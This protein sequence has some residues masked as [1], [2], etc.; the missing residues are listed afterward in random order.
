MFGEREPVQFTG[1]FRVIRPGL[2]EFQ[3]QEV[4]V[5]DLTVPGALVPRLIRQMDRGQ[6][7]PELS[8]TGLPLPIPSYVGDI[9]VAG[10]KITLYKTVG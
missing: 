2:A 9:R 4:K 10:G 5:R 6:R 3:V 8:P 1:T 7:P